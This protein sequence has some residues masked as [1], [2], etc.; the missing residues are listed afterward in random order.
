MKK[1]KLKIKALLL[2]SGGLD[3][4]LAAK[5]LEKQGTK[6]TALTFVSYFF[7]AEQ[8]KK[9]AKENKI[10][11][12]TK[13]FSKEHFN[14]VKNPCYGWGVGMNPCIDCHLL[15]LKEAKK[16]AARENYSF[17]AT[18][19]VLGQRPMSQNLEALKLIEKKTGLS[20]R[21]LRPLSARALPETEMEK[22]GIVDRKKLLG[23]SGKSRKEQLAIAKKIG[24]KNYPT[25]AGGCILTDKEYSRKLRKL[26]E[27]IKI[28]KSSDLTLLRIGRHFWEGKTRI[29][30]GR[31][32]EENLKLKKIA[33]KGDVLL[34]LKKIPG[35]LA[36]VRGK[37]KKAIELAKEKIIKYA[38][39]LKNKSPE[40]SILS[41]K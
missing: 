15:M 6:V 24:I 31:N 11:L 18:G 19:E 10:N 34:E 38:K 14:I 33:D 39:K 40:F 1:D 36:L 41:P 21:I 26:L 28:I 9:S 4:I 25:P 27:N 22:S 3:S 20:K 5:I 13:D 37:N 30:L 8:A 17:I 32:H 2:F 29:V 35:P 12:I 23:I 7:G 16:I